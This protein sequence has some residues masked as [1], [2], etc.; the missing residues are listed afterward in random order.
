MSCESDCAVFIGY[1]IWLLKER[2]HTED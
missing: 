1:V 2:H